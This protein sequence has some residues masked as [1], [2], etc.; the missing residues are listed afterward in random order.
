MCGSGSES[1]SESGSGCD[2]CD[3][4][5]DSIFIGQSYG[6]GSSTGY[7]SSSPIILNKDSNDGL[8]KAV[9]T[10]IKPN[11]PSYTCETDIKCTDGQLEAVRDQVICADNTIYD[12]VTTGLGSVNTNGCVPISFLGWVSTAPNGFDFCLTPCECVVNCLPPPPPPLIPLGANVRGLQNIN[13]DG[14]NINKQIAIVETF[15][16]SSYSTQS[17]VTTTQCSGELD[18]FI[19]ENISFTPIDYEPSCYDTISIVSDMQ[20]INGH[21]IIT[22]NTIKILSI[23]NPISSFTIDTFDAC[24]GSM[25]QGS[26]PGPPTVSIDS[27]STY[28]GSEELAVI[29][30]VYIEN[31]SLKYR[32][33]NIRV[34]KTH[35]VNNQELIITKTNCDS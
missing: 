27:C 29:T 4:L 5:P 3:N 10:M 32:T 22:K 31:N 13:I 34:L 35:S 12:Q 2:I 33:A 21:L 6:F 23:N 28:D 19:P 7:I 24:D 25:P 17:I 9:W 20:I 8:W 16:V 11:C 30:D 14:N 26:D 18:N 1:G 15:E